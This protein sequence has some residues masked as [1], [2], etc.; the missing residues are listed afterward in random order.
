[1]KNI[2]K[3]IGVV[4]VL[5]ASNTQ[6]M[7]KKENQEKTYFFE[8][9]E[10][11]P[12][13]SCTWQKHEEFKGFRIDVGKQQDPYTLQHTEC[14]TF[15]NLQVPT[16]FDNNALIETI[17]QKVPNS[18]PNPVM[19][20]KQPFKTVTTSEGSYQV[21]AE[22]DRVITD[23]DDRVASLRRLIQSLYK[24]T[25]YS[26]STLNDVPQGRG[27]KTQVGFFSK[28]ADGKYQL[29]TSVLEGSVFVIDP[30]K[31]EELTLNFITGSVNEM[32]AEFFGCESVTIYRKA[33]PE[34]LEKEKKEKEKNQRILSS[35][36]TD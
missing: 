30:K 35:I 26:L 10:L 31:G 12:G 14:I 3:I 1:M 36:I 17:L 27:F 24:P 19:P 15:S 33:T 4:C 29:S 2:K 11:L 28:R 32:T 5:L 22:G 23:A 16:P 20:Y 8:F 34:M 25:L 6:G 13:E 9:K 7:E 21:D 18:V